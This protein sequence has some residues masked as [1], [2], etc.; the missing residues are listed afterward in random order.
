MKIVMIAGSNR[1]S[2]TS[3][4]LTEYLVRIAEQKGHSAVLFDL[5]RTPLPFYSPDESHDSHEGLAQLKRLLREA[6]AIVLSSPE[7][8]GS[9]S[10][11][12]KNAID[13][14]GQEH[15][16]GKPVLSVSSAG[17]A[18]GV[19]SL[20]QLQAVIRNLHGIN[21]PEWLSIGG[22]Q[23]KWFE[24]ASQD[25]YEVGQE[26]DDRI[27]RVLGSFLALAQLVRGQGKPAVAD[28]G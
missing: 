18:V 2:A 19:S 15:F 17:G 28:A 26:I 1:K 7:Y 16:G 27:H 13:H 20:Q 14:L 21:S 6:D 24:S 23:R 4:Q 12:L 3:T 25:A 5:Y 8:H 22:S 10:G 11:V 9:M